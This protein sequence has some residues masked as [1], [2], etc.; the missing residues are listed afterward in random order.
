MA[1]PQFPVCRKGQGPE[2]GDLSAAQRLHTNLPFPAQNP[3]P[4]RT[5]RYR[6]LTA[7]PASWSASPPTA[8]LRPRF[9]WRTRRRRCLPAHT[10]PLPRARAIAAPPP[11]PPTPLLSAPRAPTP[12]GSTRCSEGVGGRVGG[13]RCPP[14][15][16]MV[17]LGSLAPKRLSLNAPQLRF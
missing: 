13:R 9:C 17:P 2:V 16:G 7:C 11:L 6:A 4:G 8:P 3:G 1:G 5:L 10:R 15:R 14:A 12:T